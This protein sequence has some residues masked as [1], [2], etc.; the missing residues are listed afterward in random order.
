MN[1]FNTAHT[2]AADLAGARVDPN[3]IEKALAY[4]R[5]KRDGAAFFAYLR[6][7]NKNGGA[8]I[9]SGQT[10]GYYRELL[11]ACDRHLRPLQH[12]YE[13]LAQTLGWAI[14][15]LRYYR[16]V[17]ESDREPDKAPRPAAPRQDIPVSSTSAQPQIPA[18]GEVFGGAV[19]A[20]DTQGVRVKVKQISEEVAIGVIKAEALGGKHYR[21]GDTARVEVTGVRTLKSGLQVVEV[22]PAPKKEQR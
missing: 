20:V 10:L 21:V 5:S 17:P 15:L 11:T 12:D 9:R 18:V 16:A 8:V 13:Q 1:T 22:K 7:I 3:E 2:L 14:R 4:L 19:L 6:A